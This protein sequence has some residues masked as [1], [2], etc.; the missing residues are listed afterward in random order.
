MQTAMV[1]MFKRM[2]RLAPDC[3]RPKGMHWQTYIRLL[4]QSHAAM[5]PVCQMLQQHSQDIQK[6]VQALG[7]DVP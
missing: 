7:Y 6:Q 3:A 2:N 4:E 5:L 1:R